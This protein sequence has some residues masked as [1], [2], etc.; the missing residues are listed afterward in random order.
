LI[1]PRCKEIVPMNRYVGYNLGHIFI[2]KGFHCCSKNFVIDEGTITIT[3]YDQKKD[4]YVSKRVL[5]P[6]GLQRYD[7]YKLLSSSSQMGRF[8]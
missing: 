1:C 6:V 8:I 4:K 2:I 5:A 7:P 3:T